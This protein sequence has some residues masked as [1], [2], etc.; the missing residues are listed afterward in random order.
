MVLMCHY[1]LCYSLLVALCVR[2]LCV[3][4]CAPRRIMLLN[5]ILSHILT[6]SYI[7]IHSLCV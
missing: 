6:L 5:H 1:K 7:F 3:A 2:V 4:L